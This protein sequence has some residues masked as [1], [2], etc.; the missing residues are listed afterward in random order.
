MR[1][2]G[3]DPGLDVIGYGLV[4][5]DTGN[6]NIIEGGVIRTSSKDTLAKRLLSIHKELNGLLKDLGPDIFAVEELYSHYKHPLTAVKMA[7]ARGVILLSAVEHKTPLFCYAPTTIK[8]A[9]TGHGRAT[10]LQVQRAVQQLLKLRQI[11]S[12][13]DV[14]DALAVA[15]CHVNHTR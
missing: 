8:K 7:H 3:I 4:A 10:K 2:L 6:I 5:S 12:P 9:L 13:P 14:A 11:P 15:I 1:V